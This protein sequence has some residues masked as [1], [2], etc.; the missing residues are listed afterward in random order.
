MAT[1][2][3]SFQYHFLNLDL[4]VPPYLVG[5]HEFHESL[6]CGDNI[7]EVKGHDI[8]KLEFGASRG[9]ILNLL[10]SK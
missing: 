6:V 9:Y 10:Y 7:F 3:E 1:P 2:F 8:M 5:E 4:K